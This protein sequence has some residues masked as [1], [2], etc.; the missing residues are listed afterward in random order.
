MKK[1]SS[2]IF[3]LGFLVCYCG[4]GSQNANN[5]E[6]PSDAQGVQYGEVEGT[7]D[8]NT[9]DD[10]NARSNTNI[11]SSNVDNNINVIN[12]ISINIYNN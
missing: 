11:S 6:S 3:M 1:L 4:N 10:S 7:T 5:E 12:I 2:L 9:T 8:S